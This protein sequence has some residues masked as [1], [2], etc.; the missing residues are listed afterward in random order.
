MTADLRWIWPVLAAPF[1]GSFLGVLITRLPQGQP[2]AL[3]RSRCLHCRTALGVPDLVPVLSY[4]AL[5]GRCR[6]CGQGIGAFHPAIELAATAVAVVAASVA[7]DPGRLWI[8]CALGWTLLTL[9]W[10][11]HVS[12]LLPDVLTL[13]LLLAGLVVTWLGQPEAVT[14]HAAAATL[15]YLSFQALA[16]GYRRLRGWDGL[17]GGDAKLI[18]AAGAWCG[19]AALPWIVVWSALFGLVVALAGAVR[20]RRLD[21]RVQIP[22]GPCIGAAFWMI[23][24][25]PGLAEL[26]G[27]TGWG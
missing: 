3:D 16:W 14:D 13:P 21:A 11:D 6:H 20:S 15:G 22:F 7:A 4:V 8:D 23:W 2:V 19:L 24:L 12:L 17:G 9:G 26:M 10:I 27:P 25:L 5:R 18:A 1:I